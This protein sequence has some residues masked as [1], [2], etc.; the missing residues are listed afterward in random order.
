MEDLSLVLF[1]QRVWYMLRNT[2]NQEG[3]GIG[4]RGVLGSETSF[5]V[6]G[7]F[8]T[9]TDSPVNILSFTIASPVNNSASHG[10]IFKCGSEIS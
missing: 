10:K 6:H 5:L 2:K 1:I 7:N 3:V 8:D 9:G 4:G